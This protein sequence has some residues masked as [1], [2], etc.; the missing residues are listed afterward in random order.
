MQQ[1]TRQFLQPSSL[2]TCFPPICKSVHPLLST[3]QLTRLKEL[4]LFPMMLVRNTIAR[5]SSMRWMYL[6]VQVYATSTPTHR[7]G[8]SSKTKSPKPISSSE[9]IR[10]TMNTDSVLSTVR[11]GRGSQG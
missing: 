10:Q 6:L 8:I 3:N 2:K 9:I 4:H 7:F 11:V 1:Q 5:L